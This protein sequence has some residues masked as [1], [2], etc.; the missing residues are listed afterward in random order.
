[1]SARYPRPEP[2]I[3]ATNLEIIK[4]IHSRLAGKIS[5]VGNRIFE[6]KILPVRPDQLPCLNI[7]ATAEDSVISSDRG[8]YTNTK[9]V[10]I[11]IFA[12]GPSEEEVGGYEDSVGGRLDKIMEVIKDEF[13]NCWET[14]GPDFTMEGTKQGIVYYM[15]YLGYQDF[16][17]ASSEDIIVRRQMKFDIVTHDGTRTNNKPL[18]V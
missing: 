17:D 1:M 3:Q 12:K 13:L 8:N 10:N 9:T 11:W 2:V 7:T 5:E 4:R 18:T 15:S 16:G 14:L 6:Y